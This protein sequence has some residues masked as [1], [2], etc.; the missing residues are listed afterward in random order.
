MKYININI[1]RYL[2]LEINTKL[3]PWTFSAQGRTGDRFIVV[4]V[5]RQNPV[6]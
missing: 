1:L 4:N 6:I 5:E 3:F 2:H